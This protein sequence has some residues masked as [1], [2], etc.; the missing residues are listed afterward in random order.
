MAEER[1][2]PAAP[3]GAIRRPR[4]GPTI[5]LTATEIPAPEDES[6]AA[7]AEPEPAQTASAEAEPPPAPPQDHP[8]AVDG[9]GP[10]TPQHS[11]F[12]PA[13]LVAGIAGGAL[14]VLVLAAL[15]L[16]G[17]SGTADDTRDNT[18]ALA[19]RLAAIE[20]RLAAAP[21]TTSD[22]NARLATAENAMKSLGVALT[23]LSQR[24]DSAVADAAAARAQAEAADKAVAQLRGSVQEAEKNTSP[25]IAP[26][27]LDAVRRRLAALDDAVKAAQ[28]SIARAAESDKAT[29]LAVSAAT[30]NAMAVRGVPY[31]EALA[32]TKALGADAAALAPLDHFAGTGV[33]S[34]AML[35]Q[36]LRTLLPRLHAAVGTPPPAGGFLERLEANARRL[37]RVRPVNAPAG[38][39]A[40]AV[41]ARLDDDAAR[42]D[43]AAA[44]A[45]LAK[46]P[47]VARAP[48][49][50]WIARA[51]ARQAAL[52]AAGNVAAAAVRALAER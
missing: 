52:A 34:A 36:D 50:D 4:A 11:W 16:A 22:M 14:V 40:A 51:Q 7:A 9:G 41:L 44:R 18:A 37:V 30:L 26:A 45:D 47:E 33:P 6:A 39:D 25:T 49:Q 23:A 12:S 19:Q 28:A 24:S 5:D 48:A 46:L 15:H 10:R 1:K 27:E 17:V 2:A 29:R 3:E 35:T 20:Q 32:Q 31:A 42:G 8:R 38:D 21:A 13:S 43:I